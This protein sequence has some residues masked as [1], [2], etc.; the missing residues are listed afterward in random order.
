ML[1]LSNGKLPLSVK[2]RLGYNE[3]D[4]TWHEFL[5]DHDL[6][7]LIIHGRTNKQMSKVPADWQAIE[8]VRQIS[9]DKKVE[10]L[11]VGNGDV[12]NRPKGLKLAK[13]HKLEGNKERK[14]DIT[15]KSG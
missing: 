5:L 14:S 7:M 15:A 6:D 3:V 4:F 1:F 10:T 9:D 12:E 13:K 11:I 2:T 8:K